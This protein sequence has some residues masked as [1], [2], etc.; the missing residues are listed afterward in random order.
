[1]RF[2]VIGIVLCLLAART[3]GAV[4]AIIPRPAQMEV[5]PGIFTLCPAQPIPGAP[6]PATTVLLA[7][8]ASQET[9]QYLAWTLF[10]STG[11]RFRVQTSAEAS[12]VSGAI[13]LTTVNGV[14]NLGPEGYELTVAPDSVLIRAPA[15][16]GVFYGVQSLLQLFPPEILSPKPVSGVGWTA[17]CVYVQDQPRFPWRGWM[18]D[19]ARH[20]FNKQEVEQ[21]LDAMALHKLNTFHWHLVDDQ[22]WRIEILKYPN[23]TQVGAWRNGIDWTGSPR[24]LNARASTAWNSS[25]KYGGY[26]TQAEI[27]E[28][29]AY[30]QQ[31]HITIVP[32][33]EM[34]GHSTAGVAA[35]PQFSCNPTYAYSM[36]SPSGTYDKRHGQE[37]SMNMPPGEE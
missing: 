34:P 20:F 17:P 14:T 2:R 35:Y 6:A 3:E 29:V 19:V 5:R 24:Y 4:P 13:V 9:A 30:A 32:E 21:M 8:A 23:L 25:G 15:Q 10:K 33:I 31:R 11:C 36:D 12:A 7:D 16:A 28:I 1:M 27:R 37:E 22:G 18:V 26:Y